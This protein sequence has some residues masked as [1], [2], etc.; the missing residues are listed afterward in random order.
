MNGVGYDIVVFLH[1][2]AVILLFMGA[3]LL[4]AAATGMAKATSLPVFST[5]AGVMRRFSPLMGIA[6]LVVFVLGFALLG[7]NQEKESFS[8]GTPWVVVSLVT[9]VVLEGLSGMLL[10]PY[11]RGI[12]DGLAAA[13]GDGVPAE[14]KAAVLDRKAWAVMFAMTWG[15][16]GIVFLMLVKPDGWLWT[17]VVAV[18]SIVIGLIEGHLVYRALSK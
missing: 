4:H 7:M 2:A 13:T 16:V 14:L 9:F 1:V 17:S 15:F 11:G 10:G 3:A 6:A 8:Y 18:V 12:K 5:W